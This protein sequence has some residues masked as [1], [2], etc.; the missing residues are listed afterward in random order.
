M[1]NTNL[2]P[3]NSQIPKR[4]FS[5]V[6]IIHVGCA[7]YGAHGY[8]VITSIQLI[9]MRYSYFNECIKIF[10]FFGAEISM[11]VANIVRVLVREVRPG[12]PEFAE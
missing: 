2:L 11:C 9:N 12:S 5:F 6:F 7:Y 10:L 8:A 3:L 4:I 1:V